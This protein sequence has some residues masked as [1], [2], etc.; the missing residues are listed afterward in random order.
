MLAQKC[1]A[2]APLVNS[3]PKQNAQK[4]G[5]LAQK[6]LTVAP[7]VDGDAEAVVAGELLGRAHRQG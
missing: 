1:L 5:M 2:V 7:L 4:L 6:C 3:I